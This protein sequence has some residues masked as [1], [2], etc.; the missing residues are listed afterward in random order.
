MAEYKGHITKRVIDHVLVDYLGVPLR[1]L[2]FRRQGGGGT[3]RRQSIPGRHETVKTAT[4]K[5]G[6]VEGLGNDFDVEF[7]FEPWV[8]NI[9]PFGHL[10]AQ[11]TTEQE[12][13]FLA[14]DRR[15]AGRLDQPDGSEIL[16]MPYA[17]QHREV[18]WRFRCLDEDDVHTW[19]GFVRTVI[20]T[21][22]NSW[23][24]Q[25]IPHLTP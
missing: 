17:D 12:E 4:S 20:A 8:R 21:G 13:Q 2:G 22:Y 15:I 9:S 25:R 19:G 6:P 7:P 1:E 24:E 3:W 11:L 18:S 5:Y 10:L 16:W 14:L 23:W